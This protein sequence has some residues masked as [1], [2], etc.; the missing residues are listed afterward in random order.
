MEILIK[1]RRI[2]IHLVLLVLITLFL[3][4]CIF[5]DCVECS[6]A[7]NGNEHYTSSI[8]G[9]IDHSNGIFE[10]V[11]VRLCPADYYASQNLLK[12][13]LEKSLSGSGIFQFDSLKTGS[14]IIEANYNDTLGAVISQEVALEDTVYEIS[15]IKLTKMGY[16]AGR[17]V[18][19][20]GFADAKVEVYGLER[21]VQLDSNNSFLLMMPEG[22]FT[23][24]VLSDQAGINSVELAD[25]LVS[26]DKLVNV[27]SIQMA[28]SDSI[29]NSI[30][31]TSVRGKFILPDGNPANGAR[32]RV[33]T[34]DYLSSVHHLLPQKKA[35]VK[36]DAV[37]DESGFF[38][39]DSLFAGEYTIEAVYQNSL[40]SAM[41]VEVGGNDTLLSLANTGLSEK[42]V[43]SGNVQFPPDLNFA[44]VQ[45]Y[46]LERLQIIDSTGMLSLSVP[47]G[48]FS[49]HFGSFMP[50]LAAVEPFTFRAYP[51]DT[52]NIDTVHFEYLS[53]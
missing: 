16:I 42:V 36:S 52:V 13:K 21:S 38:S 7:G 2:R 6:D 25:Q 50:G 41:F 24:K 22:E 20:E 23:L 30:P 48:E 17:I 49:L 8:K 14:Y 39:C 44:Y 1:G 45:V 3:Q 11:N 31:H 33:R 46:G 43:V 19:F 47:G 15:P 5:D 53:K 32:V 4:T 28:Y 26:S 27:G 40:Y 35:A 10:D 51:G 37:T 29:L 9:K 34:S 12:C 18:G